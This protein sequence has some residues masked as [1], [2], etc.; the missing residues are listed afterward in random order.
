MKWC[1]LFLL[2]TGMA[3]AEWLTFGGDPQRTGWARG[4]SIL[5]KDNVQTIELKWKIQLNNTPKELTSLTPP[6]VVDQVKTPHGIK[7]VVIV[8]GSS[9]TLHAIDADT[10]KLWWRKAF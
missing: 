1:L 10:G 5:N 3:A 2:L 8:A 7:W 9:D 4:E 6:V